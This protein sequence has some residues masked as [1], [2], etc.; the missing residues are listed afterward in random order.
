[1]SLEGETADYDNLVITKLALEVDTRWTAYSD[2]NKEGDVYRCAPYGP[3]RRG[4]RS[5]SA[6]P[7]SVR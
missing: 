7:C 1:M 6:V 4:R 3:R 5:Q 2:C